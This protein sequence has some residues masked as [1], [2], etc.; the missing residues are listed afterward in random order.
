MLIDVD[1]A[2][3]AYGPPGH[4]ALDE[5]RNAHQG[6]VLTGRI[7]GYLLKADGTPEVQGPNDPYPGYYI[8]CTHFY[9]RQNNNRLDPRRYLDASKIHYVVR[10]RFGEQCHV[11]MGDFAVVFS[12]RYRKSVYAIVGDSGN[13]NGNEGSLALLQALGYPFVNGK[14]GEVDEGEIVIRYFPGSNPARRFFATQTA[15]DEAAKALQLNT[16]F[17]N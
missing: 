1:G 7:V 2:P 12:K 3:N 16:E 14:E 5:E 11:E 15:L 6:T 9:D 13:D 4:P 17:S 10:G 8:S